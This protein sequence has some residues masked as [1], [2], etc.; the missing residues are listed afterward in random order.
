MLTQAVSE[1]LLIG[2]TPFQEYK[3]LDIL[4]CEYRK[5]NTPLYLG[6]KN[7]QIFSERANK[8]DI[9]STNT[10]PQKKADVDHIL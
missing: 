9:S 8:I 4:H 6:T 3:L 7:R 2:Y 1:E 5:A 10:P